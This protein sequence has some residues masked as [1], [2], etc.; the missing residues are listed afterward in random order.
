MSSGFPG[1]E[2]VPT[3]GRGNRSQL[4]Y[5]LQDLFRFT[6]RP[7][8]FHQAVSV[9]AQIV[10]VIPEESPDEHISRDLVEISFFQG[11]QV[12]LPDPGLFSS[13]LQGQMFFLP[14]LP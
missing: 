9:Q 2:G 5:S 3:G 7:V 1:D 4:F 10:P 11:S 14:V 8:G 12:G 13:L 6:P